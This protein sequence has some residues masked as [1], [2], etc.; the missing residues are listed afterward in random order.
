VLVVVGLVVEEKMLPQ[1]LQILAVAAVV[2]AITVILVRI[3]MEGLVV[4][5]L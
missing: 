5:V 4:Q 2:L 3:E 1:E